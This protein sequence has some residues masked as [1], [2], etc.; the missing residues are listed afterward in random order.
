LFATRSGVV[1]LDPELPG[2]A[3]RPPIVGIRS[4]NADRKPLAA[5]SQIEPGMRALEIQY[6]GVNLTSPETVIYRYRLDGFDESWQDA[7]ARTEA[8]YT[9]VPPGNYSFEV[10]ASNGDGV[11]TAPV[12]SGSFTVL[13]AFYQTEWFAAGT[14]AAVLLL[15]FATYRSH[16]RRIS[17]DIS[18]RFDER[19]AERTRVAR[20]LHDTLLQTVQGSKLVADHALKDAS[21][22]QG[23]VLAM[24][25]VS[26]WLG[27]A[28]SEGRDALNS[29]RSPGT[30]TT[31]LAMSLRRAIDECRINTNATVELSVDGASR[32]LHPIVRDDIYRIGYEAIRNACFHSRGER[33]DVTLA[34]NHDLT[35][36]ITDNGVGISDEIVEK[37]KAGHFGLRGMQERAERIGATFTLV[38]DAATGSAITLIVPGR[39]AFR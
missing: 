33:I 25:R 13:P 17:H 6:L 8:I 7:G 10:M 34:Y 5:G 26:I 39:I 9:R 35:M 4:I 23:M 32:D 27:Q 14:A 12:S 3:N 24:Q 2:L 28:I 31:D 29:L 22:Q 11:W 36:R 1:R 18:V 30:D 20:D 38:T 16:I 19:L 21:D 37:G 15:L